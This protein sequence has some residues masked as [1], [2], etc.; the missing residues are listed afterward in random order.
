[1]ELEPGVNVQKSEI[2]KATFLV[3][4]VQGQGGSVGQGGRYG[5]S[6]GQG[7]RLRGPSLGVK[8]PSVKI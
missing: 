6:R 7:G 4:S 3:L 5:G 8:L 1:M 2:V